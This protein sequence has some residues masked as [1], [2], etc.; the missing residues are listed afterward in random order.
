MEQVSGAKAQQGLTGTID[1]AGIIDI[2]I[3]SS[4]RREL[5]N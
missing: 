3:L 1:V 4:Q 2:E 5:G